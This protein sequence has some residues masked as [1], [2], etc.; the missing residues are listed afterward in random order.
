VNVRVVWYVLLL[1]LG[2]LV[3]AAGSLAQAAWVPG[4][5]F[6]ALLAT[7]GV[8]YGGLRA[9]DTQLGIV[10]PGAGW[11][12]AIVLLGLGR[13]EGDGVFAGG[14]A[15]MVY[16]LGGMAIAVMCATLSRPPRPTS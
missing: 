15:E 14:V 2:A 9:T 8:F 6:V 3:G 13:P 12:A 10:A 11:L 1:V 5:L 4:G 16:L 7:A